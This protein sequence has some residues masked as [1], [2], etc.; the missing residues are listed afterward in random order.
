MTFYLL[1]LGMSSLQLKL[2]S[3]MA[4][5]KDDGTVAVD[6]STNLEAASLDLPS[7]EH[8]D[9]A[10]GGEPLDSSDLQQSPP[11]QIVMLIVGTR[12]D[13]QVGMLLL[14]FDIL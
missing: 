3:R 9:V 4:T 7:E 8:H 14:S 5:L 6:I 13:V 12:G 11:M 10:F 2:F 1:Q